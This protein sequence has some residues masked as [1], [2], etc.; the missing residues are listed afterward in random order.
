MHASGTVLCWRAYLRCTV[1]TIVTI[2]RVLS[3]E[4]QR[5]CWNRLRGFTGPWWLISWLIQEF[6]SCCPYLSYYCHVSWIILFSLQ[7]RG[8]I[9]PVLESHNWVGGDRNEGW[10][11]RVTLCRDSCTT[12]ALAQTSSS[13]PDEGGRFIST[14]ILHANSMKIHI[15]AH[16]DSMIRR[17][18]TCVW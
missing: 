2:S 11:V 13:I 14:P 15:F 1:A 17:R 12:L 18:G 16:F 8:T 3:A 10:G 9:N 5:L 4:A 6:K 7:S